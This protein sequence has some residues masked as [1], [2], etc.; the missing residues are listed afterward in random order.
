[1]SETTDPV[2]WVPPEQHIFYKAPEWKCGVCL[3]KRTI[4]I[5]IYGVEQRIPCLKCSAP[6]ST[7]TQRLFS[8]D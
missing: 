6:V 3:D 2:S 8:E 7:T 4:F 1:M 5:N